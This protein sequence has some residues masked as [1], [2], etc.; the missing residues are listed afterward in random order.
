MSAAL[1]DAIRL[2]LAFAPTDGLPPF[3]H[4]TLPAEH[5]RLLSLVRTEDGI[6]SKLRDFPLSERPPYFCISYAWGLYDP[7][8]RIVCNG[9]SLPLTTHLQDGLRSI[10]ATDTDDPEWLWV[11]AISINQDDPGEKARCVSVM[12]VIFR[13]ADRVVVWLGKEADGSRAV[14]ESLERTLN[15]LKE[16]PGDP[17]QA[18]MESA[19]ATYDTLDPAT[20]SAFGHLIARKW[21]QRLWCTQEIA[22]TGLADTSTLAV[23]CGMNRG[24][25]SD[26]LDIGVHVRN[27]ALRTEEITVSNLMHIS[28][29]HNLISETS[30]SESS[31]SERRAVWDVLSTAKYLEVTEPVDKVYAVRSLLP[32]AV[33]DHI[34]VDYSQE[35][36]HAYWEV[37]AK[38]SKQLLLAFGPRVWFFRDNMTSSLTSQLPSW[39]IDFSSVDRRTT[40]LGGTQL[41]H[42]SYDSDDY[43]PGESAAFE[44]TAS[45]RELVANC[46]F[47][48]TLIGTVTLHD[49]NILKSVGSTSKRRL[50]WLLQERE[51]QCHKLVMVH[52]PS[53][54]WMEIVKAMIEP[55]MRGTA[56]EEQTL[57]QYQVVRQLADAA[58]SSGHWE[59]V[60][61]KGDMHGL[62]MQFFTPLVSTWEGACFFMTEKGRM[63]LCSMEAKGGDQVCYFPGDNHLQVLSK[64]NAEG[65]HFRILPGS[66]HIE[67]VRTSHILES[68]EFKDGGWTRVVLV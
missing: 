32:P 35:V 36:R 21:F 49:G 34:T 27:A 25:G 43:I 19:V 59:W 64:V 47:Y 7:T 23:V 26:L 52:A 48:D 24:K 66:C 54:A 11:D 18:T 33:R 58:A 1:E 12:D 37:W 10:L 41:K 4:R 8:A 63:G 68:D 44:Q 57:N 50:C 5:I 28:W 42:K 60:D 17:S 16:R 6:T 40:P 53:T 13:D 45:T 3:T 22:Y 39:A 65:D 31:R 38:L 62:L 9:T 67:G 61:Q 46:F 30:K 55:S 29:M 20:W 14:M 56:T 51:R 15:I 2:S